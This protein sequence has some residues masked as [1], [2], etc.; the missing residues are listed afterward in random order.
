MGSV[1]LCPRYGYG[2]VQIQRPNWDSIDTDSVLMARSLSSQATQ[3]DEQFGGAH[4][5]LS[6]LRYFTATA[7]SAIP[8]AWHSPMTSMTLP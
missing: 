3:D 4:V 8:T 6:D 1:P 2:Y 5:G 7:M